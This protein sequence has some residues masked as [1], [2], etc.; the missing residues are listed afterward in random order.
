MRG[1]DLG[2]GERLIGASEEYEPHENQDQ[3]HEHQAGV[4]TEGL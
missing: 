4:F 2:S 1:D 3:D